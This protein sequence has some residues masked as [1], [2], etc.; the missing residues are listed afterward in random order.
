MEHE[1]LWTLSKGD[2]EGSVRELWR[3]PELTRI[4]VDQTRVEVYVPSS[5]ADVY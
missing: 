2:D 4:S 1:E 5:D 3:E